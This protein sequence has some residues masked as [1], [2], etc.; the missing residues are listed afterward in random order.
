M[1]S[2]FCQTWLWIRAFKDPRDDAGKD[3][4]NYFRQQYLALRERVGHLANQISQ[5]IPG[6]TVHDLS[7]LDSLWETAS[8][9]TE[10]KFD[11]SPPAAFVFGASLLLHDS[12]L[13]IAAYPNGIKDIKKTIEW[14]DA[15]A[16]I[17]GSNSSSDVTNS[18]LPD[19]LRRLHAQQAEKLATQA[20]I[21]HESQKQHLIEDTDL[22][23]FYGETIGKIAHS[24]WW[25]IQRIEM[26]F[27]QDLGPF[28]TRTR[29]RVDKLMVACLLRIADALH[30]DLLRAPRFLRTLNQP[31]GLSATHWSFQEKLS[32]PYVES[33][34]VVFT[35][36]QSFGRADVEAWWLAYDTLIAIDRELRD[37]DLLLRSCDR[38]SLVA[39]RIKGIE[40]PEALSKI[41][42]TDGWRPVN[43][44]IQVSDV[45]HIITTLG[46]PK[47]YGNDPLVPLRELIQNAL[48]AIKARRLLEGRPDGW[49]EVEVS[50]RHSGGQD[51]LIV[52]DNGVGM[53][54]NVLT[55]A[56]LD[57]GKSF[58]RSSL[59][60]DEYPGL[61][62]SGM[63]AAGTFG[64]GFFSVFMLGDIVRV[65]TRRFD[66]G[67]DASRILEIKGGPGG[68]PIIWPGGP[69]EAPLDGGTRVEVCLDHKPDAEDGFLC[70]QNFSEHRLTLSQALGAVA[71]SVDV[72]V[73]C[74]S[75]GKIE[76]VIRPKDWLH[77]SDDELISRI[78]PGKPSA[79]AFLESL[80]KS[81]VE[82]RTMRRLTDTQGKIYGR[83]TIAPS[84]F[85]FG[86]RGKVTVSG[87]RANTI[88]NITGV[89]VGEPV[90][91]SRDLAKPTVPAEVLSAWA[92][93]QAKLIGSTRLADET[94]AR[95]AE[96]VLECGGKI[97]SLP[98]VRWAREWLS[99]EEFAER[100]SN[101]STIYVNFDGEYS[102][103]EYS[104]EMH[105]REFADDFEESMEIVNVPKQDGS[106]IGDRGI[107]WPAML[108]GRQSVRNN[109]SD[110]IRQI[111]GEKWGGEVEEFLEDCVVGT[112]G[113]RAVIR[114]VTGFYRSDVDNK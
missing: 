66:K 50:I 22:R 102:Y 24:H 6:L 105:P 101:K 88:S 48:D 30:V 31:K 57:F 46:G 74:H 99:A 35:N 73:T 12:A 4:Q 80:R 110:R 37:V 3:E 58:W 17:D 83:A 5:D 11:L 85:L 72:T 42:Q 28:P 95:A 86:G 70:S 97:G 87:L 7:H 15:I 90:T 27:P 98:I 19:V 55:G 71:P 62:S 63:T 76:Q 18:I 94:K 26:E 107:K 93:E 109:L 38:E 92:T 75:N 51:W 21:N 40:S 79:R 36:G 69:D 9:I 77:I 43:A 96:V 20:W 111:I 49:G 1:N 54:E 104:D 67:K 106:I 103:D 41:V 59:V 44:K 53:S 14:R 60:M 82:S 113:R 45:P 39:R 84:Q 68:R 114:E 64:I 33:D 100:I 23:S 13:T 112:A 56:L 81:S 32:R 61:A 29:N 89:I 78:Y 108:F 16:R 52:Q 47:L 91:A 65:I 2:D 34:A 8:L 25:D 10:K